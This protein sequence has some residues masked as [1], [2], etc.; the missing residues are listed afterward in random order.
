M[1]IPFVIPEKQ[2]LTMRTIQIFP[3]LSGNLN[4]RCS[5]MF[6]IFKLYLQNC[7][8]FI[9]FLLSYHVLILNLTIL[10]LKFQPHK[11]TLLQS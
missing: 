7:Q 1:A 5:R 3:I 6:R 4:R 2:I 9:Y 10:D 8:R 11:P